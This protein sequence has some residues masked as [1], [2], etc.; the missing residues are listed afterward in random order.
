[1]F[2][3]REIINGTFTHPSPVAGLVYTGSADNRPITRLV[4]RLDGNTLFGQPLETLTPAVY[5]PLAERLGISTVVALE[6]DRGHLP[7]VET[8]SRF[9]SPRQ[10]GPFLVF[11]LK[12]KIPT[13]EFIGPR[14]LI[15]TVRGGHVGWAPAGIAFYPHWHASDRERRE[16]LALRADGLGMLEVNIPA[17][18]SGKVDLVYRSGSWESVGVVLTALALLLWGG[19]AW[20]GRKRP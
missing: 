6:E 3:G 17:G 13:P 12:E 4:E 15:L 9:S 11:A 18:Q 16:P 5:H 14:H 2:T 8:N 20:I 1:M 19:A 7:F 10:V